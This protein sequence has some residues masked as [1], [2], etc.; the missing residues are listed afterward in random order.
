MGDLRRKINR[1]HFK[2]PSLVTLTD[3]LCMENRVS[4]F[5]P[6]I[7]K[8]TIIIIKENNIRQFI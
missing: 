1:V 7:V 8:K 2:S 6:L 3:S 4:I 5:K